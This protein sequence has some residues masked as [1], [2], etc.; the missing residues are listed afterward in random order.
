[1]SPARGCICAR[2]ERWH[3]GPLAWQLRA[4][5]AVASSSSGASCDGDLHK[6]P[7]SE[8][9]TCSSCMPHE[10]WPLRHCR[11][12]A[13]LF[14]FS[15]VPG[16]AACAVGNGRPLAARWYEG[17]LACLTFSSF[18]FWAVFDVYAGSFVCSVLLLYHLH[19]LFG[20]IWNRR[21]R[22]RWHFDLYGY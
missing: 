9:S 17:L 13:L 4:T 21:S 15:L 7:Y 3:R 11:Q 19:I 10:S 18:V 16:P 2:D 6:R 14:V 12:A 8:A 1:M 5:R 20:T 22:K